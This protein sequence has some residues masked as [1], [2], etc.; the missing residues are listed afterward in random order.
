[1]KKLFALLL[2]LTLIFT[3]FS[4]AG[5]GKKK[6][7]P[8]DPTTTQEAV[9]EA[10]KAGAVKHDGWTD[11]DLSDKAHIQYDPASVQPADFGNIEATDGSWAMDTFN[12]A[13]TAEKGESYHSYIGTNSSCGHDAVEGK[14]TIGAYDYE[15]V[16]YEVGEGEEATQEFVYVAAF[17]APAKVGDVEIY[18]AYFRFVAKDA[19]AASAIES[20]LETLTFA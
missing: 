6:E 19:S 14:K 17:D 5:C 4:L 10:P 13:K 9:T 8:V 16:T 11:H 20:V 2:A 3:V 1:M 7:K 18:A 15:T 12:F